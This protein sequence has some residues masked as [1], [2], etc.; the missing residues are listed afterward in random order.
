MCGGIISP[1]SS[2]CTSSNKL[3]DL[4]PLLEKGNLACLYKYQIEQC[5][6]IGFEE[7][8]KLFRIK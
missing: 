2:R 8:F 1:P 5:I 3:L 7:M 6:W 4:D